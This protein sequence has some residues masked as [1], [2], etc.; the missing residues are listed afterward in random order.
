MCCNSCNIS[1]LSFTTQ[2]I[3]HV[4]TKKN[5]LAQGQNNTHYTCSRGKY[6]RLVQFDQ[7]YSLSSCQECYQK[8]KIQYWL[9]IGVFFCSFFVPSS[10]SSSDNDGFSLAEHVNL[11]TNRVPQYHNVRKWQHRPFDRAWRCFSGEV[12]VSANTVNQVHS[13]GF[14]PLRSI[15][16][17]TFHMTVA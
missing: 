11:S 6:C 9:E 8:A 2:S 3:S 10:V 13:L 7:S 15:E 4:V 17:E 12:E 1:K 14:D 16:P 5:L